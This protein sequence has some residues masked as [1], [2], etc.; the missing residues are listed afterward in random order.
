MTRQS[1][2]MSAAETI[3]STAAGFGLSL[4]AGAFIFPAFGW[5]VTLVQNLGVTAAYTVLS[6]MRGYVVRRVFNRVRA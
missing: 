1:R 6:L 2:R 5:D 4:A 3:T